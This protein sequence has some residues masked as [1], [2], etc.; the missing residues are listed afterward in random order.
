M[1]KGSTQQNSTVTKTDP[2]QQAQM[3]YLKQGWEAAQNLYRNQ[4]MQ[5]YPGQ[6]LATAGE[7]DRLNAYNQMSAQGQSISSSLAPWT[8]TAYGNAVGG[9]YGINANPATPYYNA[10][11]AG[12]A[13]PQ[14]A[15]QSLLGQ[16]QGAGG[17]YAQQIGGYAQPVAN[18]A[19]QAAGGNLGLSQL[20]QTASGYYLNSNPYI[21]K[22][23]QAAQDPVTRNYQ[24]AIQPGMDAT[25]STGGRYGSGAMAGMYDTSQRNLAS[26]LGDISTNM[27]NANYARERQAQDAAAAQYGQLANAGL[28]LGM[29]GYGQAANIAGQG[30]NQYWQGQQGA[31]NALGQWGQGSQYG[32]GGLSGAFGTGNQAALQ[33]LGQYPQ[34]AQG[35]GAGAQMQLAGGTGLQQTEQQQIADQMARYYGV[36]NAPYE[37]LAKY[38]GYIGQPVGGGGTET[39]PYY[40]N[41]TANTL[42]TLTGLASLATKVV[43]LFAGSDRR[44]KEDDEIIGAVGD[45]PVHTFRYKGD[46]VKRIGYMADEVEQIDPGAVAT[47]DNGYKA[48][49]YSRAFDSAL[50]SFMRK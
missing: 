9:G 1:G 32:I 38:L 48:V 16:A 23:I 37:S 3:P 36:Q 35:L 7:N 26:G 42:G 6:T 45:L 50:N 25:L 43:P 39:T 28:G 2:T 33:A 13:W 49:N 41:N 15:W 11:A 47:M 12:T 34:L 22:A 4:P 21:D 10:Y 31:Q 14:Q 5:Y 24:T 8:Q 44:L 20:G 30:A 17:Q 19:G 27:M 29:Q 18:L 40:T 46:P